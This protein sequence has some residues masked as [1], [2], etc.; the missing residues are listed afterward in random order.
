MNHTDL[1]DPGGP[2]PSTSNFIHQAISESPLL[3]ESNPDFAQNVKGSA[4][5]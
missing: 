3:K 1:N 4:N 5:F 2:C